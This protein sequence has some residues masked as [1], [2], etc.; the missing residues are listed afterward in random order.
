M[1]VNIWDGHFKETDL[2]EPMT[3]LDTLLTAAGDITSYK[4]REKETRGNK[5]NQFV[6]DGLTRKER[7]KGTSGSA[8]NQEKAYFSETIEK[9]FYTLMEDSLMNAGYGPL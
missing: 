2:L 4:K 6:L 5:I 8:Y 1:V 3:T 9:I 7:K